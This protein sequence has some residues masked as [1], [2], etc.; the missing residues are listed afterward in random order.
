MRPL[1]T[2]TNKGTNNNQ[3]DLYTRHTYMENYKSIAMCKDPASKALVSKRDKRV[4]SRPKLYSAFI[5]QHLWLTQTILCHIAELVR[6]TEINNA[7]MYK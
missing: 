3:L 7:A 4:H 6:V 2:V 5:C 1:Y